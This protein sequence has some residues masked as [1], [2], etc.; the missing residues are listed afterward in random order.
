MSTAVQTISAEEYL[1]MERASEF[2]HEL[3]DGEMLPMPGS[4]ENHNQIS[5]NGSVIL[6]SALF[7]R[8]CRVFNSDMRVKVVATGLY[9]YPDLS[10]LCGLAE[11]EDEVRDT[12]LNPMVLMEILSPSTASYDR[13]EKFENYRQIPSLTDFIL[14]AQDRIHVEQ[15]TRQADDRWQMRE[16]KSSSGNIRIES[17]DCV[18]PI[19]RLYYQVELD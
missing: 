14:V 3:R 6:G 19:G 11:F 5:M 16:Y 4:R 1:A 2:K 13:G 8:P 7:G 15:F 17:I 9:T 12:L 18:I 10:A